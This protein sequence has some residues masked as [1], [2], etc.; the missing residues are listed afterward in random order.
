MIL[1]ALTPGDLDQVFAIWPTAAASTRWRLNGASPNPGLLQHLT[2]AGVEH[3]RV[4]RGE[5]G[6]L[7]GIFQVCEVDVATGTGYLGFMLGA[8]DDGPSARLAR[9]F[10]EEASEH[11]GLRVVVVQIDADV[12]DVFGDLVP[13]IQPVGR[14]QQRTRRSADSY[15]DTLV[16]EFEP[17][18][19]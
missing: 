3:Q 17:G 15:V 2:T 9:P 5:P 10:L 19:P 11:L 4:V 7:A 13:H 12:A 1:D 6:R 8:G 18:R 14:L 16:Y